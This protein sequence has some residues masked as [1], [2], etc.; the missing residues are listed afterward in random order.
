[1]S[2]N[3]ALAGLLLAVLGWSLWPLAVVPAV[4]AAVVSL[5]FACLA[6][7]AGHRRF[8]SWSVVVNACGALV[9]LG[10]V[11]AVHKVQQAVARTTVF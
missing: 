9:C 1:M 3:R 5:A 6:F 8:A 7:H 2:R 10:L 11:P 4:V